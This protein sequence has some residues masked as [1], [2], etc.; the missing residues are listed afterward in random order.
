[1]AD[2]TELPASNATRN[3]VGRPAADRHARTLL[4]ERNRDDVGM[5]L[6][7]F[8]RARHVAETRRKRQAGRA[9]EARVHFVN[10]LRTGVQS[11][12]GEFRRIHLEIVSEINSASRVFRNR[13]GGSR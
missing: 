11:L 8:A 6:I 5:M 7:R 1:M 9:S 4:A 13:K 2:R 12:L 3:Y 10:R